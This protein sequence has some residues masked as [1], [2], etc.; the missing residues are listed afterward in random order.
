MTVEAFASRGPLERASDA[1]RGVGALGVLSCT[2]R[3]EVRVAEAS[4][5]RPERDQ[6][7]ADALSSF[8]CSSLT[9]RRPMQE[10]PARSGDAPP[11]RAKPIAPVAWTLSLLMHGALVLGATWLVARVSAP[12]ATPPIA[13]PKAQEERELPIE[14]E[15]PV[16]REVTALVGT[17]PVDEAVPEHV[18]PSGGSV[19]LA[20]PELARPGHAGTDTA[21]LPAMNLAD[22]DDAILLSKDPQSR[23][24]RSQ[25]QRLRTARDRASLEDRRAT[26][27]PME[28][29]FLVTG[30]GHVMERR[31]SAK[32]DPSLG[33]RSSPSLP[34]EVGGARLG[35][36]LLPDGN[37]LARREAGSATIGAERDVAGQGLVSG[38]R[39]SVHQ[40]AAD[41]GL[42]RPQVTEARPAVP[43]RSKDKPRDN[44][45]SEQEV[46]ATVQSLL[47]AS[48]S[49]GSVGEG[50]GGQRGPG[51]P[52][53]GGQEGPGALAQVAG[54]G[55]GGP[56][57]A[58]DSDARLFGYK[59]QIYGRIPGSWINGFPRWAALEGRGGIVNVTVL[60]LPGGQ[61]SWA[62]V[63]RSSGIAAFDEHVRSLVARTQMP[64]LPPQLN[65][66]SYRVTIVFDALN[67]PVR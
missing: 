63:T 13:A 17:E 36:N 56:V 53:S 48:T 44:V 10:P 67:A 39:G 21:A 62:K 49:G 40:D 20:R 27:A 50:P 4:T 61:V 46:A 33:E 34:S 19:A 38:A 57:D 26:W 5:R 51:R 28:L 12:M 1:A 58:N 41:V 15:L 37:G 14:L 47:H 31:P 59:R 45:D 54:P 24:D 8:L 35:A 43:A 29:T 42:A 65:L 52:A 64:P 11:R 23:L 6:G 30:D 16:M 7:E 3:D 60:I 22:S 66:R 25:L 2:G 9:P 55:G 32:Q 18:R